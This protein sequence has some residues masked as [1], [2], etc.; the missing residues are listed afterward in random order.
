MKLKLKSTDFS[1]N[2]EFYAKITRKCLVC[3]SPNISSNQF[4]VLCGCCGSLLD[5]E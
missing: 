1:K 5:F 2:I 4:G 3:E